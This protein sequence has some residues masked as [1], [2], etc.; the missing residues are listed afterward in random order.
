MFI[1]T[2]CVRIRHLELGYSCSEISVD[3]RLAR[4]VPYGRRGQRICMLV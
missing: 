1:S 2:H 3:L 4:I